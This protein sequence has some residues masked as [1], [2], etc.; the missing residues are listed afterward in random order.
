VPPKSERLGID[1]VLAPKFAFTPRVAGVEVCIPKLPD[2]SDGT[3]GVL[4]TGATGFACGT[5]LAIGF[6]VAGVDILIAP[7]EGA[8]ALKRFENAVESD[9]TGGMIFL[10]S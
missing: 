5:M 8:D 2:V 4:S 3:A 7:S 1:G 10:I 9:G 6:A